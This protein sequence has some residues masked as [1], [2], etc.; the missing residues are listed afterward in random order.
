LQPITAPEQL[1][2]KF[3]PHHIPPSVVLLTKETE[4]PRFSLCKDCG[5]WRV[6]FEGQEFYI[7]HERGMFY[8]A[9]LLT[10]PYEPIHAL[11]L[12]AKIPEIYRHQLGLPEIIDPATGKPV[13]LQSGAR[14]QERSLALD[15]AQAMRALY[16]KQKQLEAILDDDSESEPV[17]TEALRE[18]EQIYEFQQQHAG[19]SK[20]TARGAAKAVRAAIQRLHTHISLA[21][22]TKSRLQPVLTAF[23]TH[24]QRHIL[25]P[26]ARYSG[27]GGPHARAG[28]AGSFTY[29]QPPRT[30]WLS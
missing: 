14:L 2:A 29:E 3:S 28:S 27:H 12:M 16:R 7:K 22:D 17:K 23:A 4:R 11:D 13:T 25:I 15:D 19:R 5:V 9:Y 21:S 18:L 24:L 26:S 1:F 6:V 30:H 10:H 8:V 20:D